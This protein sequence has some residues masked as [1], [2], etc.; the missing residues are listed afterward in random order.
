M[1]LHYSQTT[2]LAQKELKKFKYL[3]KLHYSQTVPILT[4]GVAAFKYLMKLH[5]SQTGTT[6][7][8]TAQCLNTL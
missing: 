3:M 2:A 4:A 1:K 7:P 8:H 5:Y 6:T